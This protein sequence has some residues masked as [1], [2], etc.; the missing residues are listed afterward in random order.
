MDIKGELV[1]LRPMTGDDLDLFVRWVNSP[2]TS[3]FWY[4]ETRPVTTEELMEDWKEP[5]EGDGR[6]G[7]CF[8]IETGGEPVGMV[9]YSDLSYDIDKRPVVASIDIVIGDPDRQHRGYGP[10]AIRALLAYLF[11]E[12]GFHRVDAVTYGHNLR[13]RHC[14]QKLGFRFEGVTREG[15]FVDACYVDE[16]RFGMLSGEFDR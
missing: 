12:L 2:A 10:D 8:V 7:R 11:D 1:T 4:G 16:Y 15:A 6:K 3:P 13:M 9:S 14:L 5:L